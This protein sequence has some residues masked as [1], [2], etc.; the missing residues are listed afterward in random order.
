MQFWAMQKGLRRSKAQRQYTRQN[1]Y[2]VPS[3]I[4]GVRR[5]RAHIYVI[6]FVVVRLEQKQ[7]AEVKELPAR[8]KNRQK[9]RTQKTG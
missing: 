2:R 6:Y 8:P 7:D 3:G 1:W 9:A 4:S 5:C